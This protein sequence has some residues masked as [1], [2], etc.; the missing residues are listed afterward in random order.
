MLAGAVGVKEAACASDVQ[1]MLKVNNSYCSHARCSV[2]AKV[3][4]RGAVRL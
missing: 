1:D 3:R 4:E 2:E